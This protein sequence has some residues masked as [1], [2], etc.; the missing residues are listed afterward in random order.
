L[1][2]LFWDLWRNLDKHHLD[3]LKLTGA[4]FIIKKWRKFA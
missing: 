1:K 4:A 2:A 3:F